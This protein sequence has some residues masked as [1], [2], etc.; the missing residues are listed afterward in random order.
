VAVADPIAKFLEWRRRAEENA[1]FNP[2]SV[3]LATSDANGP[4]L[5]MVYFRGLRDSGFSFFTN[6]ESA[7]GNDLKESEQAAMLF[8]WPHL[9]RQVRIEG[10]CE[11][12]PDRESDT[13]FSGRS[14]E[15]QVTAIVSRQSRPMKDYTAF[16]DEIAKFESRNSNK[17]LIRPQH[18]GGFKLLPQTIEFWH[19]GAHRR[20]LRSKF[21][22]RNDLW[23]EVFLYP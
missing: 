3:A 6:F 9:K 17:N 5:R 19:S 18:W 11:R 4:S 8:Y 22:M 13:Y 1:P 14:Y 21:I 7:K 2:D 10:P 12:L 16:K 20:H 15:S 23:N